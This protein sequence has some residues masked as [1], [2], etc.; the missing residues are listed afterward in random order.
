MKAIVVLLFIVL[1]A[2]AFV[3]EKLVQ[4]PGY[5][6]ISYDNTT[7]ET[8]IWVLLLFSFFAFLLAHWSLNLFFKFSL[9]TKQ[10][11]IW[12]KNRI[13][14][15]AQK[16]TF[17]GLIALSEGQWWQAQRLLSQTAPIAAQPLINYLGAAKAAHEQ[18]NVEHT[19]AFFAKA[20]EVAPDA[21]VSIGLQEAEV[22]IDRGN[23]AQA[24]ITLKRLHSLAPKHTGILRDLAD[25]H[26]GQQDWDGLIALLPKLRKQKVMSA[27]QLAEIE[28]NCYTNMLS[29]VVAKLPVES[30]SDSRVKALNRGW[31]ALPNNLNQSASMIVTY[32][33]ALIAAKAPDDAEKFLRAHIKR[34]WD[35]SLIGL[36]G[37]IETSDTA[38]QYNLAIS[39]IKKQPQQASLQLCAARLATFNQKWQ[40][41]VIHFEKSIS[42]EPSIDA[43]R[44][45]AKLLES[46]GEHDKALEASHKAMEL[47]EDLSPSIP[48][49]AL[50][51]PT[52]VVEEP[53]IEPPKSASA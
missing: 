52:P 36:Y 23:S 11:G 48:L 18:G 37:T 39:W 8:S 4:D 49:P 43:Y 46:L 50:V 5:V 20:R 40:E 30:S 13:A 41:A 24:F 25:L 31:K 15:T 51:E 22:Q 7:L 29:T 10:I 9:P 14:R 27:E 1:A 45:L 16:R 47:T 6:L 19:D 42:I 21:E 2:G 12:R 3:G 33:Q 34:T 17:K 44:S 26:Q 38:R 32:A 53:N 35:N 28:S